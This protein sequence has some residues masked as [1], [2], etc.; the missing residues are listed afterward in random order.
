M[1][2]I[3]SAESIIDAQLLCD[4][5]TDNG[6]EAVVKGTYLTGAIGEL[7]PDQLVSVWILDN[8]QQ[9]FARER[10]ECFENR[11]KEK[12]EVWL[13]KQ[14]AENNDS[15]FRICWS[16]GEPWSESHESVLE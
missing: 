5:L 3:Y 7:P 6:V 2:K 13:C 10:V 9:V 14:C 15:S 12:G 16:C 1:I 11:R 4:D 8:S